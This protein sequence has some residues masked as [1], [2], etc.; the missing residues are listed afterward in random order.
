ML[1]GEAQGASRSPQVEQ[2]QIFVPFLLQKSTKCFGVQ[3]TSKVLLLGYPQLGQQ[4][5]LQVVASHHHAPE[6]RG[7]LPGSFCSSCLPCPHGSGFFLPRG[8]PVSPHTPTGPCLGSPPCPLPSQ[9][10]TLSPSHSTVAGGH[11]AEQGCWGPG[12]TC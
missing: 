1:P 7:E 3:G 12:Q 4:M 11:Q 9:A 10:V 2:E 8:V 6:Q 5:L